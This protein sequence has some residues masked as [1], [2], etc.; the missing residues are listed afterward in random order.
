MQ[1]SVATEKI[2][3]VSRK[4]RRKMQPVSLPH[5]RFRSGL[6]TG[7]TPHFK[8][9]KQ[10]VQIKKALMGIRTSEVAEKHPQIKVSQAFGLVAEKY[11]NLYLLSQAR[12]SDIIA[13]P[14]VG[15][16]TV[17]RIYAYLTAN[18]VKTSWTA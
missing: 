18:N 2:Q 14:G 7:T 10:E 1:E 11:P 4:E 8:A 12:K 15:P 3:V 6:A 13:L 5:A 16:A 17:G 9:W